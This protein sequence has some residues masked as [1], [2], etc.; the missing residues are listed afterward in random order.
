MQVKIVQRVHGAVL[1]EYVEP[2][3]SYGRTLLPAGEVGGR[4]GE[5]A[6]CADP[7]QGIPWGEPWDELLIDGGVPAATAQAVAN[8]LRRVG[9]WT[10]A[11]LQAQPQTALAAF[12]AGYGMDVQRLREAARLRNR[13]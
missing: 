6:E 2:D 7:T 12:Q 8:E 4:P 1:V 9:I 13:R 10:L 5:R 3:G 11:E